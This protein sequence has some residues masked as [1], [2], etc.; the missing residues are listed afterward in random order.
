[1]GKIAATD[2][3]DIVSFRKR[4]AEL[5]KESFTV[6]RLRNEEVMNTFDTRLE[7]R[8][9]LTDGDY[10]SSRFEIREGGSGSS[11]LKELKDI[12]EQVIARA[13]SARF[14]DSGYKTLYEVA[15]DLITYEGKKYA[16]L[17]TLI[18]N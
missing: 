4:I 11:E 9:F 6:V 8:D 18:K 16:V 13:G 5:E 7:A 3:I 17:T 1:M 12:R 2:T 10:D 14:W 15:G